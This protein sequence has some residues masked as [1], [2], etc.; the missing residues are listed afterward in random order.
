LEFTPQYGTAHAEGAQL[1]VDMLREVGIEAT[2]V[3]KDYGYYIKKTFRGDYPEMSYGLIGA[4]LEPEI[5]IKSLYDPESSSNSSHVNDPKMT[6][7]LH[8][9]R[10][11]KAI[12]QRREIFA[13]IQRY[14][15]DR[16]YYVYASAAER[17]ASWQP[18]V[19]NYNT[20][21]GFDYGGRMLAAWIDKG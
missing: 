9:Q 2:L 16:A 12:E 20:N 17:L 8:K 13:E 1:R 21:L 3:P 19:K 5:Y 11:T 10:V 14:A 6:E 7:L 4:G 18:H 15:A